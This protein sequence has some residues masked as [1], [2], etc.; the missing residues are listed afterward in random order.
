MG[1]TY[2][3]PGFHF[4]CR[5]SGFDNSNHRIP[6]SKESVMYRRSLSSLGRSWS[7]DD[8]PRREKLGW[9]QQLLNKLSLVGQ[10]KRICEN[11]KKRFKAKIINI[12]CKWLYPKNCMSEVGGIWSSGWVKSLTGRLLLQVTE[13]STTCAKVINTCQSY[14]WTQKGLTGSLFTNVSQGWMR[15]R[16]MK[17]RGGVQ[18]VYTDEAN[19]VHPSSP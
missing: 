13:V 1:L 2:S 17:E 10:I 15:K 6:N 11:R 8:V 4:S 14:V 9:V 19:N 16:L 3:V 5:P 18:L 12:K 7:V